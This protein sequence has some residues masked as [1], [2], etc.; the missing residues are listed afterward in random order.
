MA[1]HE[2][3]VVTGLNYGDESKG[4]VANAMSDSNTLMILPSNSCQRA[5]TVVENGIR[6]VFRHFGSGTL[7]GAATYFTD[8]FLINP[9]MFRQ[10]YVDLLKHGIRP[11]VYARLCDVLVSPIDMFANIAVE[12]SRGENSHSSTGC[13]V[14][15]ALRRHTILSQ[16]YD[17]YGD[18]DIIAY[19]KKHFRN[20]YGYVPED[21]QEFLDGKYLLQN[22]QSDLD[23]MRS[24]ITFIKTD[25][26]ERDLLLSYK[27]IVF[28]NGQG[29]LITDSY[30]SD[31]EH[32]TPCSV[33]AEHP[34]ELI[35][36]YFKAEKDYRI[37]AMYVSRT[38]YTRHGKGQIGVMSDCECDKSEI[39]PDMVDLTNVPNPHQGTLR[40]G[41]FTL[42][43]GEQAIKR[44]HTDC[45]YYE[46]NGI[47]L[48]N[49]NRSIVITH[50][51]EYDDGILFSCANSG[52]YG[53]N[54]YTSDNESSIE[55][56]VGLR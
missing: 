15:E 6:R 56:V 24:H 50:T 9:A 42:A 30:N 55:K 54:I 26:E 44:I 32:N 52:K 23:F 12:K 49:C 19:Y 35:A 28:E 34:A 47:V 4:L 16:R 14:W 27:N 3:T 21:V 25:E 43:D 18:R 46:Q 36:K 37:N 5:H 8:T 53:V 10:E 48:P 17:K 22:W 11:K 51:N 20:I 41:K 13:G 39:N 33:G 2:I 38:Y 40:Y 7:K 31:T 29:L 1:N 45:Q